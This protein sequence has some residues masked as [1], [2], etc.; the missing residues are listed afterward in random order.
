[1]YVLALVAAISLGSAPA[2][3]NPNNATCV[4]TPNTDYGCTWGDSKT[5]ASKEACCAQCQAEPQCLVGVFQAN[6]DAGVCYLKGGVIE[7]HSKVGVTACQ[8]RS[9]PKPAPTYSCAQ[10]GARCAQRLGATHWN[11]CYAVNQSVPSLLDGAQAGK[12]T[13]VR[14]QCAV[15]DV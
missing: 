2:Y 6:G 11:P 5:A 12:Q 15:K 13:Q 4:Y 1:M 7:S 14:G 8:A 3:P 9:K 10:S